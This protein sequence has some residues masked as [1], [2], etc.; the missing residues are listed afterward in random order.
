MTKNPNPQGK[1]LVPVLQGLQQHWARV[2]VA[3]KQI[4]Q[5]S[6][7][8]FTSLFVLQSEFRFNPVPGQDYYLYQVGE[9]YRLLLVGPDE[10]TGAAPGRY[11]GHCMLQD[12]RTW[13]LELDPEAAAD[14]DFMAKVE[15]RRAALQQRIE[16]VEALE[17]ALPTFEAELGYYGKALSFIL[18]KSLRASMQLSGIHALSYEQAKGLLAAP[19]A[20][21]AD[22]DAVEPGDR[23]ATGA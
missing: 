19:D 3:P 15:A 16:G 4:D 11:I 9:V 22:Q 6:L 10:W 13:T 21:A 17:D 20:P 1:G 7:E 2:Q 23:A 8:L 5:V 12:D 18:G 14:T